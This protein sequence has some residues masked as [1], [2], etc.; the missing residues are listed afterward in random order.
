MSE[1]KV[2]MKKIGKY[3]REL[4]IVVIGVAI[5]LSAS[6]WISS[7]SERKNLALYLNTLKIELEENAKSFDHYAIQLQK[8]VRYA[9]Y[10]Q[11]NDE[12]SINQDT[13]I[14]YARSDND[15]LGW[16]IIQPQTIFNKNAFEMF[17][18][19]GSMSQVDNKEL[20]MSI[21]GVYGYMENIQLFL[22][23][24]FQRKGEEVTKEWYLRK[25]GKQ[26]IVPM[27]FFYSTDLPHQMALNCER[28]SEKIKEV[29][30]KLEKTKIDKQ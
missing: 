5:T 26:I 24:C 3:I 13:I 10:I 4:S 27:Q 28:V 20:L 18:T 8:S 22:D 2:S 6:N 16:A 11:S 14:Y 30:S 15:G 19:S 9:N 7:I 17:K 29:V 1:F 12:K 25:E 23:M 21:W